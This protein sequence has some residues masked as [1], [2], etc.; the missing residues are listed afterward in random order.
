MARQTELA[1][2]TDRKV[3]VDLKQGIQK[4]IAQNQCF[5]D[6][7]CP[8]IEKF[9]PP[10]QKAIQNRQGRAVPTARHC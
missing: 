9:R 4:C 5:S 8:L 10:F 3:N 7:P 2:C 1:Y 6:D